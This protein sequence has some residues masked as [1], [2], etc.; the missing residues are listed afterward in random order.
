MSVSRAKVQQIYRAFQEAIPKDFHESINI[1]RFKDGAFQGHVHQNTDP[2]LT[3]QILLSSPL[4]DAAEKQKLQKAQECLA[5]FRRGDSLSQAFVDESERIFA[6]MDSVFNDDIAKRGQRIP[7]GTVVTATDPDTNQ[8]IGTFRIIY[9]DSTLNDLVNDTG[10]NTGS[11]TA[12]T[13]S[14]AGT[15]TTDSVPST[16]AIERRDK[17]D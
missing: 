10:S 6:D 1:M 8:V 11:T 17:S 14:S 16:P 4:L 15:I 13:S 7:A 9:D 12:T 5:S 3:L 2:S